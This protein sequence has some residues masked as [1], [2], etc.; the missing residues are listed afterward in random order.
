MTSMKILMN[1]FPKI[2]QA[3][4]Y[5]LTDK[6]N[7]LAKKRLHPEQPQKNR[8]EF[9]QGTPICL[10]VKPLAFLFCQASRFLK[11]A[12]TTVPWATMFSHVV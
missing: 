1:M 4:Q 2:A 7:E 11:I 5:V 12:L 3:L 8:L 6:V 10:D 9:C